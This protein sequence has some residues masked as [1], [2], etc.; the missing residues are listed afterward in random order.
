MTSLHTLNTLTPSAIA[1][2]QAFASLTE[3]LESSFDKFKDRPAYTLGATTLSYGQVDTMTRRLAAAFT[4]LGL[5][6]GARIGVMLP[7]IPQQPITVFAGLRAGLVIVSINPLY[8][9]RE[10]QQQLADSG[11]LCLVI[12]EQFLPVAE[13]VLNQTAVTTIIVVSPADL[14][15]N[16]P[17]AATQA[18]TLST[19]RR[20]FGELL[21][22]SASLPG[23]LRHAVADDVAFLQYTG[24]TTGVSKGAALT[25]GNLASVIEQ[26]LQVVGPALDPKG[27]GDYSVLTA[28]PL[29]HVFALIFNGLCTVRLGGRSILIANPRDLD[30]MV[31]TLAAETFHAFSGVNTLFNALL[32]HRDFQTIN[33]ATL[34]FAVSGGMAMSQ[35]TAQRWERETGCPVSE[36]YGLTETSATVAVNALAGA[37]RWVRWV[38]RF[39]TPSSESSTM[40]VAKWRADSAARSASRGRKSCAAI[41]TTPPKR[42][43][44]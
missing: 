17:Q 23:P 9:S 3:L 19:G 30:G 44:S 18:G 15:A 39:R 29:Y 4:G 14:V 26:T 37:A 27:D 2:A 28:L 16:D 40:T 21:R 22:E 11:A 31:A 33:W 43:W 41:G 5:Q 13:E 35:A 25:H 10:L 24:G 34:R 32:Q 6:R 1:P 20:R 38:S 8:T 7:N 42:P 36:A 12:L